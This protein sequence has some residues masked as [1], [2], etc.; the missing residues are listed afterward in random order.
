MT[1]TERFKE[2]FHRLEELRKFLFNNRD[3]SAR[4]IPIQEAL[5]DFSLAM[6]LLLLAAYYIVVMSFQI[7]ESTTGAILEKVLPVKRA[8]ESEARQ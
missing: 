6:P 5:I 1:K 2:K 3:T 7:L 4:Q 8:G